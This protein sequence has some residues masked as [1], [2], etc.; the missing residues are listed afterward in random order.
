MIENGTP[1]SGVTPYGILKTIRYMVNSTA[2]FL[3]VIYAVNHILGTV[4]DKSV[5]KSLA[6]SARFDVMPLPHS[7]SK[8]IACFSVP[9]DLLGLPAPRKPTTLDYGEALD[10]QKPTPLHRNA[11]R[12]LMQFSVNS[13]FDINLALYEFE[14]TLAPSIPSAQWA[15]VKRSIQI[16][17]QPRQSKDIAATM[18]VSAEA[19]LASSPKAPITSQQPS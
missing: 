5:L 11:P 10:P 6:K 7:Q 15:R 3:E 18:I 1:I 4:N 14:A 9:C 17:F 19:N 16:M 8:F 12:V 2:E 13:L